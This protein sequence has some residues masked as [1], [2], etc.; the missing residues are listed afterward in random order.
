MLIC[1]FFNS[2]S[3]SGDGKHEAA[4]VDRGAASDIVA[5]STLQL[6][7]AK[8]FHGIILHYSFRVS[9]FATNSNLVR[10]T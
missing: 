3:S 4:D 8:E 10:P 7:K 5:K 6:N 2:G 9:D 1:I